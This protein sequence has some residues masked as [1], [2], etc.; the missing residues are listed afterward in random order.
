MAAV[1][2]LVDSPVVTPFAGCVVSPAVA[3]PELLGEL[4]PLLLLQ[5]AVMTSKNAMTIKFFMPQFYSIPS[6]LLP[7]LRMGLL[8]RTYLNQIKF[9]YGSKTWFIGKKIK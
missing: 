1:S 4:L 7:N 3:V 9:S 5:A 6:I 2:V 8:N